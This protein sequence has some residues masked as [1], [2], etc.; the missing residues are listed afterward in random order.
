MKMMIIKYVIIGVVLFWAG[1]F[2]FPETMTKMPDATTFFQAVTTDISNLRTFN[3]NTEMAGNY[4]EDIA[5]QVEETAT[6]V[7][8]EEP[9]P[10]LDLAKKFFD[11]FS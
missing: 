10:D 2:L 7:L 5:V 3:D 1:I 4:A 11:F 8:A 9:K 6:D